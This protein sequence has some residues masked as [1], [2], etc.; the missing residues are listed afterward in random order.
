MEKQAAYT[1]VGVDRKVPAQLVV[2]APPMT[3]TCLEAAIRA[4]LEAIA[5]AAGHSKVRVPGEGR[6]PVKAH[7]WRVIMTKLYRAKRRAS[8]AL[9][10][11]RTAGSE[12]R[13]AECTASFRAASKLFNKV[14][15]TE[16]RKMF[17]QSMRRQPR[18]SQS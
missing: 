1:Q 5:G 15:G 4:E 11:A 8:L 13:I 7:T 3:S 17:Q 14:K 12:Q 6:V 9:K 16:V 2:D 18:A 10:R